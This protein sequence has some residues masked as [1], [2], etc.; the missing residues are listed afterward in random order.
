[1]LHVIQKHTKMNNKLNYEIYYV[2]PNVSE[3]REYHKK[4]LKFIT[5][6]R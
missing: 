5:R 1:M 2:E 3:K 6:H 4:I